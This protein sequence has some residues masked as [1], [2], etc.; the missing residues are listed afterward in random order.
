MNDYTNLLIK[1]RLANQLANHKHYEERANS[2]RRHELNI[3]HHNAMLEW[4][5]LNEQLTP[6]MSPAMRKS[7]AGRMNQLYSETIK[8]F[9]KEF[10]RGAKKF[11]DVGSVPTS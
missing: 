9:Q 11:K 4:Q 5:R 2:L 3:K 6:S 10:D 7:Y 8:P 1:V